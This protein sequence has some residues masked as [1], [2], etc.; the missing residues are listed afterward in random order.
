MTAA[1][2]A[3]VGCV[4]ALNSACSIAI[5]F[6]QSADTERPESSWD[7]AEHK[8]C[9]VC[10]LV[11]CCFNRLCIRKETCTLFCHAWRRVPPFTKP[12]QT[13]DR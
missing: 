11:A 13:G 4:H 6:Q 5:L 9:A 10:Q 8:S 12:L 2:L 3:R 1:I 7:S